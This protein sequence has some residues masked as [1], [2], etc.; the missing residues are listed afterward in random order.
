MALVC[1]ANQNGSLNV[2]CG[3]IDCRRL[4]HD[5][6]WFTHRLA[7][8]PSPAPF[9]NMRPGRKVGRPMLNYRASDFK[10]TNSY[11]CSPCSIGLVRVRTEISVDERHWM[12]RPPEQA[13][14]FDNFN[15]ALHGITPEPCRF[16]PGLECC[17]VGA[18]IDGA[19]RCRRN[20]LSPQYLRRLWLLRR[21]RFRPQHHRQRRRCRT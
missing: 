11:S 13:D 5:P 19:W 9:R 20:R 2:C 21:L 10:T 3:R 18:A 12:T 6:Y 1:T 17:S 16:G 15:I 4:C 8:L 7:P 14:H